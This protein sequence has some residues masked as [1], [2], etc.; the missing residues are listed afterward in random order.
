MEHRDDAVALRGCEKLAIQVRR[1]IIAFAEYA[2]AVTDVI[3]S[4]SDGSFPGCVDLIPSEL[5]CQFAVFLRTFLEPIDFMPSP[6]HFMVGPYSEEE[7]DQKKSELRPKY[8]RL[9]EL[10]KDRARNIENRNR[11]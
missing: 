4:G 8:V 10:V 7:I 1:G 11:Q 6:R 2:P 3:L 9:Y 5:V